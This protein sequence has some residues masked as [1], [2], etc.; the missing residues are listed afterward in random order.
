M[1]MIKNLEVICI[2]QTMKEAQLNTIPE[3]DKIQIEHWFDTIQI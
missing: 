2:K 3:T 1:A